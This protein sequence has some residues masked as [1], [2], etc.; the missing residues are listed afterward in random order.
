M[1]RNLRKQP[2]SAPAT[3]RDRV[4]TGRPIVAIIAAMAIAALLASSATAGT[5]RLE[6]RPSAPAATRSR[7]I[8]TT[9]S[10]SASPQAGTC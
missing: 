4:A 1:L 7:A 2:S 10:R 5:P 6:R 3:R 9:A 8:S